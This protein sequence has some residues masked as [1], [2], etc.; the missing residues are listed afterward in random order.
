[1]RPRIIH[2]KD[3]PE[4]FHS[5][6][7]IDAGTIYKIVPHSDQQ[8]QQQTGQ[9][10]VQLRIDEREMTSHYANAFRTNATAEEVL[11]PKTQACVAR[12]LSKIHEE[13]LRGT[14][15]EVRAT[16]GQRAQILGEFVVVLHPEEAP[17]H[18]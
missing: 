10:Q 15:A 17:E 7:A 14:L 18:A 9:T 5:F 8:A 2:P 11:G 6:R 1:M 16:L 13:W 12:E 4:A 3:D